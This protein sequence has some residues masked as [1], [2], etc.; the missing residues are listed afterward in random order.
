[1]IAAEVVFGI[2]LLKDE[3]RCLFYV[4][5]IDCVDVGDF[6]ASNVG[7]LPG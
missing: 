4:C 6:G 1:M 3:K 2:M 7:R 5:V